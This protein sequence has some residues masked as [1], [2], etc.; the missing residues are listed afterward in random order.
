MA[1]AAD[2]YLNGL[3]TFEAAR[4]ALAASAICAEETSA[5]SARLS[6]EAI[7]L[8]LSFPM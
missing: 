4:R 8:K 3:G 5:V 6:P 1:A 7:D 2:A